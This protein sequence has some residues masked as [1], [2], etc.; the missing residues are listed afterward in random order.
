[1]HPWE[2]FAECFAHY[3]HIT[4]TIDTA[5]EAGMVLH[6]DRVRF[7]GPRDIVPLESYADAPIER[8][9]FD[10]KWIVAVLQPGEHRDGQEPAVSVRDQRAGGGQ[11]WFR[12][13]RAAGVSAGGLVNDAEKHGRQD[14]H[15]RF[16]ER[17]RRL[18]EARRKRPAAAI[19]ARFKEID[20]ST[21]SGLI[22]IQ[23]FTTVIPLIILGLRLLLRLR[24]RRQSGCAHHQR[25]WATSPA[26]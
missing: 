2:D 6:V 21:Q 13:H 22:S 17:Y 15:R 18:E 23:L 14:V 7:A 25:A 1:M 19:L 8:L 16:A 4:D 11:A 12:P 20:G 26:G 3:L 9:L 24:C 10:W 5:R